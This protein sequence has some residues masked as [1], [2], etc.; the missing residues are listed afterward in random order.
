MLK[1]NESKINHDKFGDDDWGKTF[2]LPTAADI[3]LNRDKQKDKP[4]PKK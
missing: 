2:R 1:N 4:K 3:S